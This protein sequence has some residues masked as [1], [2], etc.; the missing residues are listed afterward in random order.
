VCPVYKVTQAL[1]PKPCVLLPDFGGTL[2][3]RQMGHNPNL[4]G[5][6]RLSHVRQWPGALVR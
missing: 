2:L 1:K 6:S 4:T 3:R 5:R